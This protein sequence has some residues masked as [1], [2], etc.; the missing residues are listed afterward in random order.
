MH[1]VSHHHPRLWRFAARNMACG[2]C[3]AL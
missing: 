3:R 2:S 1:F